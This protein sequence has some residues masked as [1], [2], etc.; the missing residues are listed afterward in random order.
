MSAEV[1]TG[2]KLTEVGVIPE[3]WEVK[4]VGEL[5]LISVGRDLIEAHYSSYQDGVFQYPVFSNTVDNKGLYGFY[6]VCE[7]NGESLTVVG[8]GVGLGTAFK[9]KGR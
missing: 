7:Y 6:S 3:D 4:P 8:R 5:V 2:Y 1:K 9:R